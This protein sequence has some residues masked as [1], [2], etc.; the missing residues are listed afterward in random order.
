MNEN[1]SR[2]ETLIANLPGEF[3]TPVLKENIYFYKRHVRIPM[4][5][6]ISKIEDSYYIYA[7]LPDTAENY[8]LAI[9]GVQYKDSG[10]VSTE[11]IVKNF[12]ILDNLVDF[13]IK[14]GFVKT[15]TSF[16][17]NL[18]NLKQNKIEVEIKTSNK[19]SSSGGIFSAL[20]GGGSPEETTKISLNAGETKKLVFQAD[21]FKQTSLKTIE[22][23][24]FNTSYLI[25]IYVIGN[26][27]NIDSEEPEEITLTEENKIIPSTIPPV[28]QQDD[29]KTC[30]EFGGKICSSNE[31][32]IGESR[33]AN[34]Q[35]CCLGECKEKKD[36]SATLKIIGW[37]LLI[38]LVIFIYFFFIRKYLGM[39]KDVNVLDV[40]GRNNISF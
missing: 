31:E 18:Q 14:P 1:Y 33:D 3:I 15:S 37:I 4:E 12:T 6:E 32:C 40:G 36:N 11:D 13:N 27:S 23:I 24:Y 2:Q 7:V 38:A 22:L 25:P 21:N 26:S 20:F 17:I 39:K 16:Y 28:N 30:S 8:S 29:V 34:N 19:S 5:F 35:K 10:K 9:Q